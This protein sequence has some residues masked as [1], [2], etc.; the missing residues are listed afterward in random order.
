MTR[1]HAPDMGTDTATA[2]GTERLLRLLRL[3]L[4]T[5]AWS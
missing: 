2:T 4:S 5:R 3:L 1:R